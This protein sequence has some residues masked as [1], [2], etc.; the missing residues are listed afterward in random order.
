MRAN[1]Y[2]HDPYGT[3]P[4]AGDSSRSLGCGGFRRHATVMVYVLGVLTLV[5]LIGL[6][7]IA[8]THGDFRRVSNESTSSSNLAAVDGVVRQVQNTLHRDIWGPLGDAAIPLSSATAEGVMET[9]EPYDAPGT[10]DRWLSSSS[11]YRPIDASGNPLLA[12]TGN[13]T[14]PWD[15][16]Y[17]PLSWYRVSYLGTDI[18]QPGGEEAFAWADNRRTPMT[19]ND[20]TAYNDNNLQD[21]LVM[22]T[23]APHTFVGSVPLAMIPGSTTNVT[24]AEARALWEAEDRP[25]FESLGQIRRFPYFDTNADGVVDLYDADGDGIPDSPISLVVPMNGADANAPRQLYAVVRVVDHASMLNV[26]AASSWMLT[27]AVTLTFDES[28]PDMQRRGRRASELLLDAVVHDDDGFAVNNRSAGLMEYRSG[29]NPVLHDADVIRRALIG[30]S[31]SGLNYFLYGL[32]DEASLRHRWLLA[33]Y[34]LRSYDK[35]ADSGDYRTIDRALRGS[36]LWT[37]EVDTNGSYAADSSRWNRLNSNYEPL[38]AT[39]TYEGYDE[40]LTNAL[41]WRTLLQDD[42]P[43]AIRRPMFTTVSH[44]VVPPPAG[45]LLDATG[46]TVQG[47]STRPV[48]FPYGSAPDQDFL[49]SWPLL[50][51]ADSD[52]TIQNLPDW[53]R[54][55]GID[56]N[57]TSPE[58]GEIEATKDVYICFL[59]AAMYRALAGVQFYQGLPLSSADPTGLL[60]REWLSWQFALNVADYRDSDNVPTVLQWFYDPLN[61]LSL[62]LYGV[63]KQPFLTE[64]YAFVTVHG[65]DEDDIPGSSGGESWFFAV[66]L[67]VPPFWQIPTANLYLRAPGLS[68]VGLRPLG[69]FRLGGPSGSS[70]PTM[71]TGGT[72]GA[73]YVFCGA[74]SGAPAD[75]VNPLN[76]NGVSSFYQ[77]PL[78][79]VKTDGAGSVELVYSPTGVL[80]HPA[81]HVLDVISPAYSGGQLAGGTDSGLG[82]WAKTPPGLEAGQSAGFS[83]LRSTSGWR[84]TTCWQAYSAEGPSDSDLPGSHAIWRTLGL[85]NYRLSVMDDNIPES[86]WPA[87]VMTD[88]NEPV[89]GPGSAPGFGSGLPYEAF[90]SVSDLSRMLVIGPAKYGGETVRLPNVPDYS[91]ANLSATA[92]LGEIL[93]MGPL[94]DLPDPAAA[95]RIDF[96]NAESVS[97][98]PWTW[99]LFD[100]LTTQGPLFDGIDNDGDGAIDWGSPLALADPT[101]G[102]DVF[103]RLAGRIN[104]NTATL[105]VLRSVPGMSLLPISPE[106]T[107][108]ANGGALVPDPFGAF[109]ANPAWFWDFATAIQARRENRNVPVRLLNAAGGIMQTVAIAAPVGSTGGPGEGTGPD[110]GTTP[111]MTTATAAPFRSVAELAHLVQ[112]NGTGVVDRWGNNRLFQI[113]RFRTDAALALWNHRAAAG[114]PSY[115]GD[116]SAGVEGTWSPDYRY[117]RV[118]SSGEGILDYVPI[119]GPSE[120]ESDP[121]E[122]AGLRGRDIFLSRLGNLLTTR[123]DVFTVYI[124]LLDEDGNYVQRT[125]V[126]VDRSA[127]FREVPVDPP[128]PEK[129]IP[130]LPRI[131]TREDSGYM[132]DMK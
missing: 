86:I 3:G 90:D 69:Q 27:D 11:P 113:D 124:T 9:N 30:G 41:G 104:I 98:R 38:A 95:G 2:H 85:V 132:N 79:A 43:L 7:L 80:D 107:T 119:P 71:L 20:A 102:V 129:R 21:V 47:L 31:G 74:P 92:F 78:F 83:L 8:R 103:F 84:F 49:M 14:A 16:E 18:L 94:P 33:S 10:T 19:P 34:D 35:T 110:G 61:G 59:A 25:V 126:T 100:Y 15:I 96:V 106:Y 62:Y 93:S 42:D 46:T 23:P 37:R 112:N 39:D 45:V 65:P 63:E 58:P 118:S 77:N 22:Q 5:A 87:M 81:T 73:Y 44:E 131:L 68:A 117:R 70:P 54:I 116:P 55:Q 56:I 36:L 88:G 48:R 66:E 6:I 51:R 97:G 115:L 32:G 76:P 101:E 12:S 109:N 82:L 50:S 127:C 53:L 108:Y 57:M 64:A 130:V 128:G 91:G 24:I 40:P 122:G 105:P 123:S 52:P 60:N 89:F 121:Y 17:E 1:A 13:P 114:D 99:R 120:G 111:V 75:L 4:F 67:F 125:Q 72:T 26:N 28:S 29:T